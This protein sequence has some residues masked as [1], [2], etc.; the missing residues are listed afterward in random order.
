MFESI[1]PAP[2]DPI[3]GL[4][5]A[6]AN[7]PNPAK[8]NLSVGVYQD[9]QG[10]TP[11]LESV[12]LAEQR[13]LS[14]EQTKSYKPISGDPGYAKAVQRLIFGVDHE[15]IATQRAAT[16]HTPGGTAALRVAADYLKKMHSSDGVL[17]VWVSDPTWANHANVFQAAGL[18]VK[19]YPYFDPATNSLSFEPMLEAL[20]QVPAGD[21]VL[22]HGC[23]HNPTG[24]DPTHEQWSRIADCLA[25]R[26][27]L[28][29]VDFAYQGFADG[30]D[31][32]A[33]GLLQ[34]CRPSTL[35]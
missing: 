26:G 16:A 10:H 9:D 15:V 13:L 1:Q 30:V 34:L 3:L 27:A 24:I 8:I 18:N 4:S 21:A 14:S 12:K 31:Q 25:Q 28:P 7:D 11:I 33:A 19:T 5:E 6:F 23:C 20:D 2:P 17:T 22:L 35:R 29:L 32:D